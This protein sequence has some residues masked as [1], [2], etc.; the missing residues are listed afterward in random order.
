MNFSNKEQSLSCFSGQCELC[1]TCVG[2]TAKYFFPGY[3]DN[4]SMFIRETNWEKYQK[5]LQIVQKNQVGRKYLE[6]S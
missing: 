1:S 2:G 3:M 5:M 6:K 4:A